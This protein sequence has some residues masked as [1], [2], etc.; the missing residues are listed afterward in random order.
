MDP[1][2]ADCS[3]LALPRVRVKVDTAATVARTPAVP[4]ET[5]KEATDRY[6]GDTGAKDEVNQI[7]FETAHRVA[8][9]H[10]SLENALALVVNGP[11]MRSF[12][13]AL[14]AGFKARH[15]TIVNDYSRNPAEH[16]ELCRNIKTM[17]AAVRPKLVDHSL[18]EHLRSDP[19]PYTVAFFDFCGYDSR[20][21]DV[22]AFFRSDWWNKD[23]CI[24]DVT[25]PMTRDGIQFDSGSS[26]GSKGLDLHLQQLCDIAKGRVGTNNWGQVEFLDAIHGRPINAGAGWRKQYK[27][28]KM[29]MWVAIH[30]FRVRTCI[31]FELESLARKRTTEEA[32][33]EEKVKQRR[34]EDQQDRKLKKEL[35]RVLAGSRQPRSWTEDRRSITELMGA[36]EEAPASLD[37]L[38]QMMQQQQQ[39]SSSRRTAPATA[40]ARNLHTKRVPA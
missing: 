37:L 19:Q 3:N 18:S 39:P 2:P 4:V 10:V 24:L 5:P 9:G 23:A 1:R 34:L 12:N 33:R 29:H 31:Q 25:G 32:V 40:R 35:D 13:F 6:G 38:Q 36:H 22:A 30:P 16:R 17:S 14:K 15:I 28:I 7:L 11:S 27:G 26:L 8:Y 21:T 20:A